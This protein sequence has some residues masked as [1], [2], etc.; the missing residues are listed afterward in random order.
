MKVIILLLLLLHTLIARENPFEP[1]Y[2]GPKIKD[3]IIPLLHITSS[4]TS[5]SPSKSLIKP[6]I[7]KPINKAVEKCKTIQVTKSIPQETVPISPTIMIAKKIDTISK[8]TMKKKRKIGYKTI[9]QNYFLKVQTNYKNFKIITEDSLRK[10]VRYTHPARIAFDFDRLQYFH[11]KNITFNSAFAKKIK[12][13]SHHDFYRITVQ[14]N[15]YKHYK[16]TKRP[17]GYL[18]SFY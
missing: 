11:T 17:Y 15:R 8:P 10:K 12:F 6:S 14:L 7:I 4:Q 5:T 13:G 1:V 18:L 16:L 2:H 9:Y 3:D